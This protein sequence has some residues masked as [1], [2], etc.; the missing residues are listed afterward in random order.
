MDLEELIAIAGDAVT[1]ARAAFRAHN[2]NETSGALWCA[3]QTYQLVRE[4]RREDRLPEPTPI[5]ALSYWR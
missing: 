5:G 3:E 1:V 4:L 2:S